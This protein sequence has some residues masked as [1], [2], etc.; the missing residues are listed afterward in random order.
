[1]F[2]IF[3]NTSNKFITIGLCIFFWIQ[4]DC[5][6]EKLRGTIEGMVVANQVSNDNMVYLWSKLFSEGMIIQ[7]IHSILGIIISI[8]IIKIIA[9]MY[10]NRQVFKQ[11]KSSNISL[12][13]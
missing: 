6:Y 2:K 5:L 11:M 4:F 12:F 8:M 13:K 7:V 9:T 3:L 10:A 1:M